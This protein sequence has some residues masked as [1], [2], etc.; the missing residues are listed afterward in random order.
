MGLD[1]CSS[2]TQ[3]SLTTTHSVG[4]VL[5]HTWAQLKPHDQHCQNLSHVQQHLFDSQ[6]D[7]SATLLHVTPRIG[8]DNTYVPGPT[9]QLFIQANQT[10]PGHVQHI[11][12][13][14]LLPVRYDVDAALVYNLLQLE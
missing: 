1:E 13:E 14:L 6:V 5:A 11:S 10:R 9:D 4:L 8:E 3:Y 12:K 2:T 7:S